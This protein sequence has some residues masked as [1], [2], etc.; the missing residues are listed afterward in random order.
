MAWIKRNLLFAIGGAVAV[1]L[2]GAAAFYDY[3]G[4]SH[5]S[6]AFEKLNEIYS[7]L[8]QLN[9]QKPS[10]GDAK[11]N[12]TQTAKEQEQEVRLWIDQA[13][14][15]FKPIA[16]IPDSPEVTSEAY[17]AALRRMIDQ[18]QHEADAASVQ[19]PPKYSFSFEAQR[20]IVKFAPG[21]LAPLAVQLGEVRA[22]AGIL[23]AARVN[24][25]DGIQRA[26]VSDDDTAGSQSDYLA[27]VSITNELVVTTPYAVTFRSFTPELAKVLAGFAASPNGFIVKGVN[28]SPAGQTPSGEGYGRGEPGAMGQGYPPPIY[29]TTPAATG[30]GGLSTYLNEQLLRV[31]LEVVIVKPLPKK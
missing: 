9:D 20:Y 31:T 14:K 22:I 30:K 26:R 29:P 4:F 28:V 23:F 12:N 21:S 25:I 27:E 3:Q 1:L 10:P 11:V 2:L 17:A 15:Y 24:S 8:K 18:L 6:A 19:L 16:P 13:G 7:T 5:N